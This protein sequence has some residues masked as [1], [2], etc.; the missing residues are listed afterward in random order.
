MSTDFNTQIL[1]CLQLNFSKYLKN[2][3]ISS[4]CDTLVENINSIIKS[5]SPP[6]KESESNNYVMDTETTL[7]LDYIQKK[8]DQL[9][10]DNNYKS[11]KKYCFNISTNKF[12]I[13]KTPIEKTNEIISL[14]DQL[15]FLK[16]DNKNVL[17]SDCKDKLAKYLPSSLV[18]N[19][20]VSNINE[21]FEEDSFEN[22]NQVKIFE[23]D[24]EKEKDFFP[25]NDE[26]ISVD[27]KQK[28]L[29]ILKIYNK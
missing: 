19:D 16:L 28:I 5:K 22:N 10:L 24:Q 27:E 26:E 9:L 18:S 25:P 8:F 20:N 12:S 7:S 2:D 6:L 1:S 13:F 14:T 15:H 23:K 11:D 21:E 17:K 4:S 3:Y 29:Q